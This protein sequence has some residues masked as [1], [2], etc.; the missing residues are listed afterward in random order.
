MWLSF[1]RL[2]VVLDVHPGNPERTLDLP[3]GMCVTAGLL[4]DVYAL[5]LSSARSND[6]PM[7][8]LTCTKD[9]THGT[10]ESDVQAHRWLKLQERT[11]RCTE[12]HH[13]ESVARLLGEVEEQYSDT[14]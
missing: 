12:P 10:H 2:F 8:E 14:P 11:I 3:T 4:E 1:R 13:F 5:Y 9:P 6:A 7:F